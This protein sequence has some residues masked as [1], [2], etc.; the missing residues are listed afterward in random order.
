VS[1][2]SVT[3]ELEIRQVGGS[4]VERIRFTPKK[5][6]D[7]PF[8]GTKTDYKDD[9][10]TGI[11]EIRR[12][13]A[14]EYEIFQIDAGLYAGIIQWRWSSGDSV[15]IPFKISPG[16]ATYLGDFQGHVISQRHVLSLGAPFPSSA[17]F[18]VSDKSD[19]D[20]PLAQKKASYLPPLMN[21]ALPPIAALKSN[22]FFD[23]C[24]GT[25]C[26]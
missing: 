1:S 9:S 23:K 22:Y 2:R 13:P 26:D 25:E 16:A 3:Y 10:E 11:V 18:V 4:A 20:I 7:L 24:P 14:G 21:T 15:P 17:Y 5:V 8:M 12:L 19:R 6:A